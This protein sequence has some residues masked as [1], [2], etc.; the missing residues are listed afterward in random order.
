LKNIASYVERILKLKNEA[1]D[2]NG[3]R[4]VQHTCATFCFSGS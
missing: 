2:P 4:K 3:N 1:K